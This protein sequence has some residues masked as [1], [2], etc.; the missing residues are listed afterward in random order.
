T[1]I[2]QYMSPEQVAH[3]KAMLQRKLAGGGA[4]TRYEKQV[5]DRTG[6]TRTLETNTRLSYD[7]NGKPH[8]IHAIARDIT[9]RKKY[10][11]HL[12]FT[13]RELSHRTTNILAV[14]RAMARQIGKQTTDFDQ[15]ENRFGGCIKALAY[16]HDLLI[17]SDWQGADMQSL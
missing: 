2:T 1:A 15:F 10:E 6:Q 9:A 12:A 8:A 5:F 4:E 14:V 3:K 11:E 13:T 7:R 17:E 16:C